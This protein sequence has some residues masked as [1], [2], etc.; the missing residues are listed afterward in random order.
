MRYEV[1]KSFTAGILKGHKVTEVTNVPFKVGKEYK[2]CVN[3]SIY[4]I[5]AVKVLN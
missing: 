5:V 4:L 3:A 2:S 1:T